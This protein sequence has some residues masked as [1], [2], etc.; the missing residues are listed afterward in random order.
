MM[1]QV[2]IPGWF[3]WVLGL[4]ITFFIPWAIWMT[5]QI[6]H[7]D[8]AIALNVANDNRVNDDIKDIHT[9]IERIDKKLDLFLNHE[10]NMLKSLIQTANTNNK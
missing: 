9:I 1:E 2:T 4:F 6:F 7:Q 5:R 3:L 10:I 8:K